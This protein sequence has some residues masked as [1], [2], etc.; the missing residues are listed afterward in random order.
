MIATKLL[1]DHRTGEV[2]KEEKFNVKTSKVFY[3]DE[4]VVEKIRGKAMSFQLN[5]I[6]VFPLEVVFSYHTETD[7]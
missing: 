7:F 3:P 1:V 5:T 6:S 2:L 4:M